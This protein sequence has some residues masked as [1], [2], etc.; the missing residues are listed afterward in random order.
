ML[1]IPEEYSHPRGVFEELFA[2]FEGEGA[3]G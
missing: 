3:E 1:C 2:G